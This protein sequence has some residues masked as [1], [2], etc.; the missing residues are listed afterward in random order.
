M[1]TL[2]DIENNKAH[3]TVNVAYVEI[4]T[5]MNE[6]NKLSIAEVREKATQVK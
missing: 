6:L 5:I 1:H 3:P 2:R 4:E